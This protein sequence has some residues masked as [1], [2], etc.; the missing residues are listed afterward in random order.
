M[1]ALLLP[2]HLVLLLLPL[3]GGPQ[4]VRVTQQAKAAVFVTGRVIHLNRHSTARH[5]TAQDSSQTSTMYEHCLHDPPKASTDGHVEIK[6]HAVCLCVRQPGNAVARMPAL[7]HTL[8]GPPQRA[9]TSHELTLYL[10]CG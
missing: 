3:I 9:Q 2:S 7:P 4:V 1:F 8:T 5:G 6:D 10:K